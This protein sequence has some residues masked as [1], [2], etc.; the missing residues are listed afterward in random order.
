MI[1][2]FF[3]W[4]IF[5]LFFLGLSTICGYK[6]K[7]SWDDWHKK[8]DLIDNVSVL[9][10]QNVGILNG[11]AVAGD[12]TVIKNYLN[13]DAGG[14]IPN[15]NPPKIEIAKLRLNRVFEDF[16]KVLKEIVSSFPRESEKIAAQFNSRGTAP[17]GMHIKA[18]MDFAIDI[19]RKLDQE[20]ESLKRA[21]E[22]ILVKALNKTSL[23]S[24]GSD[25]SGEQKRLE[26]AKNRCVAVY[27]RLNDLPKSWEVRIF[28]E[29]RQTKD[30]TVVDK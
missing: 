20:Y 26:E 16:D 10:Q 14:I 22:D 11:D 28:G 17:S 18:Q 27:P 6:A 13:I 15:D 2:Q 9:N 23:Q 19:K 12:K 24:A 29:V 25:F 7:E 4:L 30:F 5:S 21:I 3:I 8:Q 1:S